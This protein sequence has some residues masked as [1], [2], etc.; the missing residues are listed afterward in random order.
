MFE[1]YNTII[2]FDTETTGLD[3]EKCRV[4]ELAAI[5]YIKSGSGWV[6]CGEMDALINLPEGEHIPEKIVE[7]THITDDMLEA[8]G[9]PEE[10]AVKLFASFMI[11]NTL[12]IAHNIQFD[13]N[14]LSYMFIRSAREQIVLITKA[15]YLDTLT[16]SK[17]RKCFPHKL[18]NMIDYYNLSDRCQNSHRAIDDVIALQLVTESLA[19]ERD[20]LDR[21]I[22]I[23]GYN[24]KYGISGKEFKK[25]TYLRQP[26]QNIGLVP[27]DTI[28]PTRIA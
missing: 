16:V 23:F 22:N 27:S 26:Y 13:I 8:H 17:D 25:V 15:D 19:D 24:P 2:Y 20:D 1:E 14:F 7:L 21:Y 28:L 6:R 3:A 9:I 10:Q 18:E 5:Q 11:G 12:L 4:I